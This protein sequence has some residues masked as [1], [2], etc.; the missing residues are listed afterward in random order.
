M[1]APLYLLSEGAL[2]A[3][4]PG[5]EIQLDGAEGR[6]AVTVRRTRVGETLL[7]ADGS[8]RCAQV[9]TTWVGAGELRARVEAVREVPVASPRFVLVQA[10]S[11][12]GRDEQA[13]E[14]ATEIGVDEIVPWQ[15]ARSIARWPP[16]RVPRSH[17]R[18]EALARAA[19]KSSRR[20][21][22]PMIAGL[23][24]RAEVVRR[25]GA[26][27]L[28]LVL[29][30]QGADALAGVRLPGAGEVLVVVGPEGGLDLAELAA[31]ET[32]GAQLVR[33]GD[34]VLR[35]SSAGPAALAVLS[36]MERWRPD[37]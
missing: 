13:L 29:H 25:V 19:A 22:A 21:R 33:L 20:A 4:A 11:K 23:A 1:T 24:D 16:E 31:F 14:T 7:L 35:S 36:A 10:L 12:G 28:A 15:A 6:H 2:D 30:E 17:A 8:G 3:V 32:A 27:N 9:V 37:G 5:Q 18:W 34:T 26:A